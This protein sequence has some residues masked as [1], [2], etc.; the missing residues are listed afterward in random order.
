MNSYTEDFL[1]KNSL[2]ELSL[3]FVGLLGF[4]LFTII[5]FICGYI[6]WKKSKSKASFIIMILSIIFFIILGIQYYHKN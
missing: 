6:G 3:F 4:N 2:T 5:A 1:T